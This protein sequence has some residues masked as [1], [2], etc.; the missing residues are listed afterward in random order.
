MIKVI[1]YFDVS[2]YSYLVYAFWALLF[3]DMFLYIKNGSLVYLHW[4]LIL[5]F[6]VVVNTVKILNS[7]INSL[8]ECF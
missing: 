2:R 6:F 4:S 7:E 5:I 1:F 3:I 8:V